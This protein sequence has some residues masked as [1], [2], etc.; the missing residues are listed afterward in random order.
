M[1][2][3]QGFHSVIAIDEHRDLD[4]AGRNHL[5]VDTRIGKCPKHLIRDSRLTG[6]PQP[7][8]GNLSDVFIA[9]Y[10][11]R[12]DRFDDVSNRFECGA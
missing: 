1:D 10:F 9:R 2:G 5:D 7:D 4:F 6:H 3:A 11:G 8:N 12:T